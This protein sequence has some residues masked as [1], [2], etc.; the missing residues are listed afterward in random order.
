MCWITIIYCGLPTGSF[1]GL[2]PWWVII[3]STGSSSWLVVAAAG[4]RICAHTGENL[5]VSICWKRKRK[6]L[7]HDVYSPEKLL[8]IWIYYCTFPDIIYSS[9]CSDGAYGCSVYLCGA[10]TLLVVIPGSSRHTRWLLLILTQ[11]CSC[12]FIT[13]WL[14]IDCWCTLPQLLIGTLLN[15]FVAVYL[16]WLLIIVIVA[17]TG[18]CLLL[19]VGHYYNIVPSGWCR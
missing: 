13:Y 3:P 10:L 7:T 18:C 17:I 12:W 8:P 6:G 19:I 16:F 2:V 14:L 11:H 5:T 15:H 1:N 4:E 9:F